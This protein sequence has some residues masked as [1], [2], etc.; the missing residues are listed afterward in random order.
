MTLMQQPQENQYGCMRCPCVWGG[1]AICRHLYGGVAFQWLDW[2]QA[3]CFTLGLSK[4]MTIMKEIKKE[5]E[6]S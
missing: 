5:S 4:L 3:S 6:H 2:F 1:N